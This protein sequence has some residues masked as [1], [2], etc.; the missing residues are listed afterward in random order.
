MDAHRSWQFRRRNHG[1]HGPEGARAE[2]RVARALDKCEQRDRPVGGVEGDD[3]RYQRQCS[4]TRHIGCE[5]DRPPVPAVG[6]ATREE[7]EERARQQPRERDEP[8]L[9]RGVRQ[10][11][12]EQGIRDR[13]DRAARGGEELTRLQE[14]EVAVTAESPPAFVVHPADDCIAGPGFPGAR[15]R[16]ET[17]ESGS[18]R[19]SGRRL[20]M[21]SSP[22]R[23]A[24]NLI[25][26]VS[27]R[28]PKDSRANQVREFRARQAT[29]TP[30][31]GS[32]DSTLQV[33]REPSESGSDHT[34]PRILRL[35]PGC[36]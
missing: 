3:E 1:A 18:L 34:R 10:R 30:E 32:R 4:R 23:N 27:V 12:Y 14:Q 15:E 16:V 36:S 33:V 31:P 9:R 19:E 25:R 20:R 22:R 2:K 21:G 8:R 29:E 7:S 28:R 17:R 35:L 6:R 26:P 11:E 24:P 13:A 5:H